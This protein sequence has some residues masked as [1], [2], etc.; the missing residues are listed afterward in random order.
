MK[1]FIASDHAGYE[2]KQQIMKDMAN[3]KTFLNNQV[4]DLGP[5]NMDSV[6]Y[7]DYANLV[8]ENL[9]NYPSD[10]GILICGSGQGMAL[11]A[12]KFSHIRA[13]LVY[14]DEITEL[15]RAHNNCNVICIGSRFCTFENAKN[16]I[17][18]FLNTTFSEGRHVQRVE[19]INQ[20][21]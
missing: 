3:D 20:P 16:W 1:I 12:N 9:K 6:D 7:P 17:N 10:F 4:I 19:K 14:N 8:C 2:L 13:A 15:S 18:I 21:T 5:S 11:R